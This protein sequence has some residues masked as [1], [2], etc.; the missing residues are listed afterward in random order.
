MATDVGEV[1]FAVEHNINGLLCVEGDIKGF[2]ESILRLSFDNE[3]RSKLGASGRSKAIEALTWDK[4][5]H[6]IIKALHMEN[7]HETNK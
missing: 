3:L 4:N 7:K 6:N 5:V 2:G 1:N